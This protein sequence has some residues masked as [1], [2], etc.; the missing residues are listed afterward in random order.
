MIRE[1]A[2][3]YQV[4]NSANPDEIKV[5]V[6]LAGDSDEGDTPPEDVNYATGSD[7]LDVHL[8][9]VYLYSESAAAGTRWKDEPAGGGS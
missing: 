4:T 3:G 5:V 1:I 2:P 8:R 7:Y 9:K 6:H